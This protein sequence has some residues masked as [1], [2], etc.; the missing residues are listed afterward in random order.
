VVKID[1]LYCNEWAFVPHFYHGL[2]VWQYATSMA[3]A[4]QFV[5]QIQG[6]NGEPAP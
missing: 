3:A 5:E 4:A 2:Y 1:P 6:G